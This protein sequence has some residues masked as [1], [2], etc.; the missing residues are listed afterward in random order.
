[1][2][3]TLITLAIVGIIAALTIPNLVDKYREKIIVTAL[4]RNFSILQSA[5]QRA[6]TEQGSPED[7]SSN[8]HKKMADFI[9]PYLQIEK[10]GGMVRTK[11]QNGSTWWL[12][13]NSFE[14]YTL[15]D[16]TN[17]SI[18]SDNNTLS[19]CRVSGYYHSTNSNDKGDKR[20]ECGIIYVDVN[21]I[22]GP[23]RLS[24]DVFVLSLTPH[25]I[26]PLGL[27][28]MWSW[29]TK[30]QYLSEPDN[31]GGYA[32][33]GWVINHGNRDYLRKNIPIGQK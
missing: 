22:K 26:I 1:M 8:S 24:H 31:N 33:S 23:N 30:C 4:K 15:K 9:V 11:T 27:P 32:C 29:G 28:G 3:E 21:G 7:W 14:T 5:Y 16:G 20:F 6:I 13:L 12:N 19:G 17:I 10:K 2:P 18:R 25:R